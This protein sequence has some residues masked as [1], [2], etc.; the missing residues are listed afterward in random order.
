MKIKCKKCGN[1]MDLTKY[2]INEKSHVPYIIDC[3]KCG[4]PISEIPNKDGL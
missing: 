3:D 1:E 2:S 4:Y